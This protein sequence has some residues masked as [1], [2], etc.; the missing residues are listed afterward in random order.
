M[1]QTA[2][3]L[4]PRSCRIS[5]RSRLQTSS[6]TR[7]M[8]MTGFPHSVTDWARVT[9]SEHGGDSGTAF[10]RTQNAGDIRVRMVE[11]SPGYSADHW[12]ARGHVVLCLEGEFET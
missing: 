10:W 6:Y 11:Y 5:P 3:A 7:F 2:P 9:P 8:K 12:C 4:F 1:Q